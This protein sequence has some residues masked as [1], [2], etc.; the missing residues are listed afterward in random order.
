[1]SNDLN[2]VPEP[3]EINAIQPSAS[4]TNRSVW[5]VDC[6]NQRPFRNAQPEP[7]Y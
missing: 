4:V 2:W 5:C 7:G 3:L 1:M 6:P